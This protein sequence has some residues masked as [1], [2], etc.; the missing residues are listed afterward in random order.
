MQKI[1]LIEQIKRNLFLK[2]DLL[3]I[4]DGHFK[5]FQKVLSGKI[6]TT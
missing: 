3:G 5:V 1:Y 6:V 4:I 2:R